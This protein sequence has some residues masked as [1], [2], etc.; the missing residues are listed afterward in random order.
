MAY[1]A[2]IPPHFQDTTPTVFAHVVSLST[3]SGG[4]ER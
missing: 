3:S 1:A 4:A 2:Q